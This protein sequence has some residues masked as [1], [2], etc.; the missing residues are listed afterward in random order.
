MSSPSVQTQVLSQ[1]AYHLLSESGEN[2]TIRDGW[3][4]IR[5]AALSASSSSDSEAS[6]EV[7]IVV[8]SLETLEF[9]G[10]TPEAGKA[11]LELFNKASGSSEVPCFLEYVK[12]HVMS[13]PDVG[14]PE[15]DW[16]AAILAM[17]ITQTLCD[18]ILDPE[19][20]NILLTETAS[21]WVIDTIEAKFEFLKSLNT[22]VLRSR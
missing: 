19:F 2:I 18:K 8:E 6:T 20:T 1:S 5:C 7:P 11:I 14:C 17:G 21:Y 22:K 15:D 4:T 9:L 12:G 16:N 13:M 10:F 3:Q